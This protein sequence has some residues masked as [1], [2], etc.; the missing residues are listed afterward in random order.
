MKPVLLASAALVGA[1]VVIA[2]TTQTSQAQMIS[3]GATNFARGGAGGGGLGGGGGGLAGGGIGRGGGIGTGGLGTGGGAGAGL[4]GRGG[5]GRGGGLYGGSVAGRGAVTPP[6][7]GNPG[8]V[9]GGG[10]VVGGGRGWHAGRGWHGGRWHGRGYPYYGLGL[11]GGLYG[12]GY[13]YGYDDG[14]YAQST[15]ADDEAE[16]EP[17]DAAA[18]ACARRFKTY[19]PRT[20]TYIGK[21]GRRLRCP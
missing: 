15:Y 8:R 19:D 10:A 7:I 17:V 3:P 2:A 1:F 6:V 16:A 21:G 14:Y 18:A 12:Y 20:G 11:A 5:F 4:G 13:P 9:G